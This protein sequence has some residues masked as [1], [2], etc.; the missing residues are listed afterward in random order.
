ML[1]DFQIFAAVGQEKLWFLTVLLYLLILCGCTIVQI[2]N[3]TAALLVTFVILVSEHVDQIL[4]SI[5]FHTAVVECREKCQDRVDGVLMP[6]VQRLERARL[7]VELVVLVLQLR[8]HSRN[9]GL[10]LLEL[11]QLLS[12]CGEFTPREGS[13]I[14][15]ATRSSELLRPV[16]EW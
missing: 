9:H 14:L 11:L 7:P 2:L 16:W 4:A 12:H 5:A 6:V 3:D 8:Y 1:R 13:N 10:L 15:V